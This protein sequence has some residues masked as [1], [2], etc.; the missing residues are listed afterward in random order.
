ML[1]LAAIQKGHSVVLWLILVDL[2]CGVG[3]N[4]SKLSARMFL[5]LSKNSPTVSSE[6]RGGTGTDKHGCTDTSIEAVAVAFGR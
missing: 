1:V 5:A 6:E 4:D 2:V 3:K